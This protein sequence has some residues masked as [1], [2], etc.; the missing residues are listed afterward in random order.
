[1][2][3]ERRPATTKK[4]EVAPPPAAPDPGSAGRAVCHGAAAQLQ[5]AAVVELGPDRRQCR[6]DA[7][8]AGAVGDAA[9]TTGRGRRDAIWIT[10]DSQDRMH[11]K[12]LVLRAWWDG[13]ATPSVEVPIGDFFGL[14][15]G[16]YFTYQ[17]ALLAVAPIKALNA[18]FQMP[19]ASCGPH[20]GEQPGPGPRRQLL[21]CRGLRDPARAARRCGALSCAVSPGRALQGMDRQLDQQC[22]DPDERQARTWTARTTTS[23]WRP[24]AR[25]ILWA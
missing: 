7:C 20:D 23:S 2:P 3:P 11:L 12:N 4:S 19:F 18:Y 6:C 10:I 25:G 21:L 15:L 17:S 24:R 16:E 5:D 22:D 8:G 13:E 14:G 1:M 9:E